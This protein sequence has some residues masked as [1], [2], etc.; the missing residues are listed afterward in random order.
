[1]DV[2]IVIAEAT[3]CP[4]VCGKFWD[5]QYSVYIRT[6]DPDPGVLVGSGLWKGLDSDPVYEKARIQTPFLKSSDL[7]SG[8]GRVEAD[9]DV[10]RFLK[11]FNE[12]PLWILYSDFL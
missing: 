4:K 6:A 7:G 3:E 11:I 10:L 2:Q 12:A 9:L 8:F 1:M 5:T